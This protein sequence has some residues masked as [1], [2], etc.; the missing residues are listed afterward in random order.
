MYNFYISFINHMRS[1][2]LIIQFYDNEPSKKVNH[3]SIY[4][5]KNVK[6]KFKQD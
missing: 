3:I 5:Y 1:L 2:I 6:E 4:S